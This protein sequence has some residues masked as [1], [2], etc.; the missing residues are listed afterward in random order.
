MLH[1]V[2]R[3]PA[4]PAMPM[5]RSTGS[6]SDTDHSIPELHG[7]S[8]LSGDDSLSLSDDETVVK[9]KVTK[10]KTNAKM[11]RRVQKKTRCLCV[12]CFGG[13]DSA[14]NVWHRPNTIR[15]HVKMYGL[16]V[17]PQPDPD[18]VLPLKP[19]GPQAIPMEVDVDEKGMAKPEQRPD[20]AQTTGSPPELAKQS[21]PEP[22]GTF[23]FPAPFYS[24]LGFV[25][26]WALHGHGPAYI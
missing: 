14:A 21:S 25:S 22:P 8:D 10:G 15:D 18:I 3:Q 11:R 4:A 20:S 6:E 12:L 24:A 7:S 19:P 13:D 2:C 16:Y 1:F 9:R 23:L 5:L 17:S 26:M